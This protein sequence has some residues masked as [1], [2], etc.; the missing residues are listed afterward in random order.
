LLDLGEVYRSEG[1]YSSA[2]SC[3][4]EALQIGLTKVA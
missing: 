1:K 3:Y 4:D 2:Q